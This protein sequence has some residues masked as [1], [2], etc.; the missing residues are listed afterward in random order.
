MRPKPLPF[1]DPLWR[2]LSDA[3]NTAGLP[4]QLEA[5]I[6]TWD[7]ET[8]SDLLFGA[9]IHQET[10][11]GATYAAFPHLL[12]LAEDTEE[13]EVL[14][15]LA[16]WLGQLAEVGF[17]TTEIIPARRSRPQGLP[18]T[19]A[20]WE[21][22]L[23]IR[24]YSLDKA[25]K[26]EGP[27]LRASYSFDP[28]N[29]SEQTRINK[30]G[31]A[32]FDAIP[33]ISE[34]CARAYRLDDPDRAAFHLRGLAAALDLRGIAPLFDCPSEGQMH[35]PSCGAQHV[36]SNYG[37]CLVHYPAPVGNRQ[38]ASGGDPQLDDWRDGTPSRQDGFIRPANSPV[39]LTEVE[40]NFWDIAMAR[41]DSDGPMLTR[42]V[43][44]R[45]TCPACNTEV[46][47]MF[48][49]FGTHD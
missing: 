39:G 16:C 28:P 1:D 12:C 27:A 8:V 31:I 42:H 6:E 5:L 22:V 19:P 40:R 25:S 49:A 34:V 32:F 33:L 15:Y 13:L 41:P 17:H 11:Y 2:H 29:P 18:T 21:Q 24:Q 46:R 4:Q 44:G 7:R 14:S 30:L 9:L 26:S 23:R 35:C 3:Y 37:G 47:P 20:D 48:P 45:Y 38:I 36:W 10:C 43:F